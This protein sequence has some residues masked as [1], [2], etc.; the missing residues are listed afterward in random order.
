MKKVFTF[1]QVRPCYEIRYSKRMAHVFLASSGKRIGSYKV[2]EVI[3]GRD[4]GPELNRSEKRMK[5]GSTVLF[6]QAGGKYIHVSDG[7]VYS[8]YTV[9]DDPVKHF[10]SA[11]MGSIHT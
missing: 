10:Y 1:G 3:P 2:K 11:Y 9:R 8:F 6:R 5:P 4:N 7:N